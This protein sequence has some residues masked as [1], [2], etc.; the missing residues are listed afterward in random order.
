MQTGQKFTKS[1]L[2]RINQSAAVPLGALFLWFVH[3]SFAMLI[4]A[5][6]LSKNHAHSFP[7]HG[8][9]ISI[10]SVL[11]AVPNFIGHLFCDGIMKSR[12]Y[13]NEPFRQKKAISSHHSIRNDG[14]QVYTI[15]GFGNRSAPFRINAKARSS[16]ISSETFFAQTTW[17]SGRTH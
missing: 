7:M 8:T 1:P 14:Q 17:S 13:G 6:W 16:L 2:A 4:T 15:N 12:L 10:P 11:T 5:Q 9:S 3:N